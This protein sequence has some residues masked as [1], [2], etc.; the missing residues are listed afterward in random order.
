MIN[1]YGMLD[2][3]MRLN[4]VLGAIDIIAPN[5]FDKMLSPLKQIA[6]TSNF[7]NIPEYTPSQNV[8]WDGNY[9]SQIATSIVDRQVELKFISKTGGTVRKF[10]NLLKNEMFKLIDAVGNELISTDNITMNLILKASLTLAKKCQ[11]NNMRFFTWKI[12][13]YR[14]LSMLYDVDSIKIYQ[15][16]QKDRATIVLNSKD[17]VLIYS[18]G[19]KYSILDEMY[20]SRMYMNSNMYE[21]SI[22]HPPIIKGVYG[23]NI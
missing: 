15:N 22:I 14:M 21:N 3:D 10:E 12:S 2:C 4:S 11:P 13:E 17:L 9:M 8:R 23:V 18:H 6:V 19:D 1:G 7:V 5:N 20:S 16:G